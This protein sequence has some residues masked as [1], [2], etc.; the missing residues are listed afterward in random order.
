MLRHKAKKP[1][2][3]NGRCDAHNCSFSDERLDTPC[4]GRDHSCPRT[5]PISTVGS[6]LAHQS[7]VSW[8]LLHSGCRLLFKVLNPR[9]N[10][11][12]SIC[13]RNSHI[14]YM[15]TCGTSPLVKGCRQTAYE[16]Q[17]RYTKRRAKSL[18]GLRQNVQGSA[19]SE[20]F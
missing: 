11:V 7:V 10:S 15:A 4:S 13:T 20:N 14:L 2:I 16:E 3:F 1:K 5:C 9:L 17:E 6:G 18:S 8:T 19:V 12:V